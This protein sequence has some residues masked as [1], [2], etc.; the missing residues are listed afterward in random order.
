MATFTLSNSETLV[1][2]G[3]VHVRVFSRPDLSAADGASA[4]L[5]LGNHLVTY[6]SEPSVSR[7][8]IDLTQAPPVMGPITQG[9]MGEVFRAWE[10]AQK[11]IVVFIADHATQELQQRRLVRENAPLRGMVAKKA[12]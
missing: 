6:A 11:R 9:A 8:V 1:R 3:T 10:R 4:A 2:E 7:L 5:A 12:V